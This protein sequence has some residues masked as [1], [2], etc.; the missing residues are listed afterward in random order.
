MSVTQ[1]KPIIPGEIMTFIISRPDEASLETVP[2]TLVF[3]NQ[4]TGSRIILRW[5]NGGSDG[6][7][8]DSFKKIRFS[9]SPIWTAE[10]FADGN[11]RKLYIL[12]GTAGVDQEKIGDGMI[13]IVLPKG[14]VLPT[15]GA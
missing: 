5:L 11:T 15:T 12:R 6:V 7:P 9:K 3:D 13:Q 2:I 4:Q 1:F 14:G 10:N 8:E